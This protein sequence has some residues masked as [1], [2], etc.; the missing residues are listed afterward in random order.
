VADVLYSTCAF[1]LYHLSDPQLKA[2]CFKVYNDWMAEFCS[3]DPLRLI[4]SGLLA[5]DDVD[6]AV[7]ELQRCRQLGLL[8][9]MIP[10]RPPGDQTLDDE[11]FAPLWAAAEEAGMVLAMHVSTGKVNPKD[12]RASY[13]NVLYFD[14]A[15]QEELRQS[16]TEMVGGRVFE[17]HPTL[18]VIAAEGGFDFAA[19]LAAKMDKA[20]KRWQERWDRPARPLPSELFG[21]NVFFTFITDQ[22][23]LLTLDYGIERSVMWSSDYPHRNS[24]WPHSRERIDSDFAQAHVSAET[25]LLL[26]RENVA[27]V[28]GIDLSEVDKP[29]PVIMG[30]I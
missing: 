9:C 14:L 6:D 7:K 20:H 27:R 17:R 3:V 19:G 12:L 16:I 11:R 29:S 2:A 28:Y 8:S 10:A 25:A 1:E 26:T 24:T 13:A 21:E 5:L 15:N 23:G 18:K 4:G 30:M 22:V